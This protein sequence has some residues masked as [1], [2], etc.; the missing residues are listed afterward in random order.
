MKLEKKV[1]GVN[2]T[3]RIMN[4]EYK[5]LIPQ[6]KA[7]IGEKIFLQTGRMSAKAKKAINFLNEQPKK[8]N[9]NEYA[10]IHYLGLKC[11]YRSLWLKLSCCFK[12]SE[13]GC[14][15]QGASVY[16]G[17]LKDGLHLT[18]VKDDHEPLKTDYNAKGIRKLFELKEQVEKQLSELK[19]QLHPFGNGFY[20]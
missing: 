9:G 13:T 20:D 10:N 16:V 7:L 6:L 18:E 19:G 12:E 15:Y 5:N 2:E 1:H 8:F 4:A 14:F 3:N 11:S 17:E